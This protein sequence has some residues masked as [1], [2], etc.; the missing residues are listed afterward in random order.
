MSGNFGSISLVYDPRFLDHDTGGMGHPE[1]PARLESIRR[2]LC[3]GPLSQVCRWM[4]PTPATRAEILA[5][6]DDGYLFRFEEECLM[7]REYF[8]HPD[9]RISYD[10]FQVAMLAAGAGM[11]GVRLAER[12]D[13]GT[14]FC[15]VRPPGHHAEP[16][17]ALGFCFINNVAVAA[18]YWQREGGRQRVAIVDFDAH[19]GNGIQTIF[20]QDP[21]VFYVSIHEHPTFSFPGTGYESERG[22]GIG[23]GRTMNIPLQPGAGD[24]ELMEAM[25]SQV[26]P[27]LRDFGP[28]AIIMAA[29]FDGLGCD[30]MSGLEYTPK[31]FARL[32]GLMNGIGRD[33]CDSRMV[34]ILEGGYETN[35]VPR[36]V[37]AWLAGLSLEL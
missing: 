6:H 16:A 33:L 26:A 27:A 32:G 7:G 4:E 10:T 12:G 20:Y 21:S 2:E 34:S 15:L 25:E 36:A 35:M 29:G 28:E 11:S 17:M 37:E 19:H 14:V 9:N 22:E 1:A 31:G 18:K 3:Q 13:A 5:C 23:E 30:D 24:D 8:G